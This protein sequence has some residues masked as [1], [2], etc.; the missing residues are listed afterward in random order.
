MNKKPAQQDS[1]A[2]LLIIRR[3]IRLGLQSGGSVNGFAG[4]AEFV[5]GLFHAIAES[6]LAFFEVGAWIVMFLITD[7]TVDF[8]HSFDVRTDVSDDGAGEGILGIGIDVHFDDTVVEGFLKIF[9]RRAGTAVENEIHFCG[10]TVFVGD[11]FL[12]IAKDGRLEFHSTG[13]VGTVNVTE[14]G[15]E[16]EAADRLKGFVNFHHVFRGGIEFF[17]RK[18]RGIVAVFFAADATG[19]DF[20]NDAELGALFEELFG[21]F[22]VLLQIYDR[23]IEH[24]RLEQ[25][26]FASGDALARGLKERLEEAVDFFRMA[27]VGMKGDEDIVF[28][29]Q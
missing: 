3:R 4:G 28:L 20:K 14:G 8:Q 15:S 22:E 19:F 5:A 11:G 9:R 7:F 12:A 16:Q 6:L 27:V 1:R 29:R 2:G 21:N 13:F 24:V 17:D 23:A 10:S 25:R 18:A 26:A